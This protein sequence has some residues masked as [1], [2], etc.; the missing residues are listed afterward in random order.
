MD[1]KKVFENYK[2]F[3]DKARQVHGDKFT[4]LGEFINMRTDITI[5]CN[6]C[7]YVFKQNPFYHLQSDGCQNCVV[8]YASNG[9]PVYNTFQPQLQPYGVECRR[10]LK[11]E[12]MLEV[13]CMYCG[14]WHVPFLKNVRSKIAAI[15]GKNNGELNLYCS[16]NCKLACPTYRQQKYPKGFK[17]VTSREVQPYLRKL[18][19]KRD[20]YTCQKC[21]ATDKQLHCHHITGIE[22]NPIESADMDNCITLCIDCH[23]EVHKQKGCTYNNFKR[24][25]CKN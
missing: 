20:N 21:E 3:E 19:L 15:K 17:Q 6:T 11:D 7:D 22:L 13:R 23:N 14:R 10:S 2:Q 25:N 24:K 18:V 12:K 9:I 16:D 8:K 4:Y 1:I 5:K